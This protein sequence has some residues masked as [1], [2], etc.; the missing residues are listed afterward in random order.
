MN[1]DDRMNAAINWTTERIARGQR[2]VLRR[3]NGAFRRATLE[4]V[5]VAKSNIAMI[6][7]V[8]GQCNYGIDGSWIPILKGIYPKCGSQEK[9]DADVQ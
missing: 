5:G 9:K 1:E 7:M 6:P 8:C 2:I 4:D 3:A